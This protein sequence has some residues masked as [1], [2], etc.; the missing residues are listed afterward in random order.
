VPQPGGSV[1]ISNEHI[2]HN[3]FSPLTVNILL[4]TSVATKISMRVVGKHE[5]ES[6][7]LKILMI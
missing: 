2:I 4:E 5:A 7:V 1:T 6:D 3:P